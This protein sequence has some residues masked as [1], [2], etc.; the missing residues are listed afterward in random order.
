MSHHHMAHWHVNLS[1]RTADEMYVR[2]VLCPVSF[3]LPQIQV[4][5]EQMPWYWYLC[6]SGI[7]QLLFMK[8]DHNSRQH[9]SVT[10]CWSQLSCNP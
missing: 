6:V 3:V 2:A 7:Q 4:C 5:G 1:V 8:L 9:T 10:L